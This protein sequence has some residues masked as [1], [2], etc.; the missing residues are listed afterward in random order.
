MINVSGYS[1]QLPS[2]I[3]FK[4]FEEVRR[5]PPINEE[6]KIGKVLKYNE[7]ELER[8]F[9]LRLIA[10]RLAAQSAHKQSSAKK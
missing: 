1:R 7:K 8:Y 5:F 9:E 10:M 4:D 2:A 6:G 3:L